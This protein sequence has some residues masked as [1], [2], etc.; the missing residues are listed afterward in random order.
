MEQLKAPVPSNMV[1]VDHSE[2]NCIQI[3]KDNVPE[4]EVEKLSSSR[5]AIMNVW[6]PIK[7]VSRDPLCL[8]DAR[9]V[10]TN[11]LFPHMI[12]LPSK[13]SSAYDSFLD[14]ATYFELL[15]VR[16]APEHKWYYASSVSSLSQE[17]RS[18]I[19]AY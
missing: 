11:D 6:R 19:R 12:I 14:E 17:E 10:S 3:L 2:S 5:W 18:M 1:H 13:G 8:C 16:A 7:T 9:S 4:A 15:K